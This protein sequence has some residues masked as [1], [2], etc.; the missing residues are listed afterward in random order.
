MLAS[1]GNHFHQVSY[2]LDKDYVFFINGQFLNKSCLF[3]SDFISVMNEL[4]LILKRWQKV[5][6]YSHGLSNRQDPTDGRTQ[7][8]TS[9]RHLKWIIAQGGKS[10]QDEV[11]EL[12]KHTCGSYLCDLW[13]EKVPTTKLWEH[14]TYIQNMFHKLLIIK[15]ASLHIC[16]QGI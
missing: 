3:Y 4:V 1:W 12:S 15:A 10:L 9:C 2:G 11:Q 7:S 6:L 8:Q 5:C 16:I 14:Y 13:V